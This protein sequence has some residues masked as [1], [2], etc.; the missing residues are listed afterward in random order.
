MTESQGLFAAQLEAWGADPGP[1]RRDLLQ[2]FARLLS[3][4][5]RANV[6][7]TRQYGGVLLEHVLDSLSCMLFRPL[8]QAR[9]LLDVGSGGGLPGIPLRIVSPDLAVVLS[10]SVGKKA[11]FMEHAIRNLGLDGTTVSN[12]RVEELAHDVAHRSA[13]DVA[14]ARAVARLSVVAEYC[15]PPVRVGG[16]VIALKGR[17]QADEFEE[18]ERAVE[19]LGARISEIISVPYLP[20]IGQKERQ[21]VILEKIHPS[22]PEYPRKPGR[23]V[24]RP[25]GVE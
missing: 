9:R 19:V 2:R 7:G 25:L 24:K 8:E 13:Y 20:E 16:H 5:E 21:L 22:P 18:G 17:L 3:D 12:E 10:E 11:D 4:Y 6:I 1:E 14:T 15:V 23:A